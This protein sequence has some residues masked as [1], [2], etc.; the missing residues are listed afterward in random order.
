VLENHLFIA[1]VFERFNKWM[2]EAA[3]H[4][5]GNFYVKL[6]QKLH[7]EKLR[8]AANS[9]TNAK[10]TEITKSSIYI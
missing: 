6:R 8:G 1:R 9:T 4:V 3:K 10:Q 5:G 2:D 7:R